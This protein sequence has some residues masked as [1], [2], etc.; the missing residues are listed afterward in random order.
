MIASMWSELARSGG[1]ISA[2]PNHDR[3]SVFCPREVP[4]YR[5]SVDSAFTPLDGEH[6]VSGLTTASSF[7]QRMYYVEARDLAMLRAQA[8][9]EAA[10]ATRLEALS[11]YMWNAFDET[12]F[13]PAL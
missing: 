5:P 13:R 8:S 9:R 4:A 6:V 11:A 7:V 2:A 12:G 3:R 1:A 10:R